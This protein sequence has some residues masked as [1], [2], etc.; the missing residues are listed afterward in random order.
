MGETQK[1][2]KAIVFWHRVFAICFVVFASLASMGG[3]ALLKEL[4]AVSRCI[5]VEDHQFSA[6]YDGAKQ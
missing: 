4:S 6:C 3:L 5:E 1:T 2:A